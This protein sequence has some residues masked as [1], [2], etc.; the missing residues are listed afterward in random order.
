MSDCQVLSPEMNYFTDFLKYKAY[1][2]KIPLTGTFELTARCNFNCNM[3]YVHLSNQQVKAV[4]RELT[5][6]EWLKIAEQAKKAGMLY[7]NLTGGEVFVRPD[8]KDL[9]LELSEMGFLIQIYSNGSLID[10]SV[11]E[12]LKKCPPY[13]LRLTL[14]GVSNEVYE[15]VCGIRNGFSKVDRAVNL[16]K[17]ADIPLYMVS[18]VVKENEKDVDAMYKYAYKKAVPF[19]HTTN[20]VQPVRGAK[21]DAL[22][23]RINMNSS[24]TQ[25]NKKFERIFPKT[26]NWLESCGSYRKGFWLTWNGK[27]QLCAFMEYP[28]EDVLINGFTISWD[29][30]LK[31]LDG[32]QMPIECKSCKYEGFCKKCPGML[33]A[34]CGAP[35][36][37]DKVFCNRAKLL[38][39]LYCISEEES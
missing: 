12:W 32:L 31:K 28:A 7:L 3:C 9:Y 5:T 14:Y 8:F 34:E 18:T 23:H 27:I 36:K 35:D 38:Y 1:M 16:I 33:A 2:Q 11:I 10:E 19:R 21:S 37:I 39:D 29:K 22:S 30:L 15:A 6:D 24:K 20:V 25:P 26:S 4:G 17:K 13:F